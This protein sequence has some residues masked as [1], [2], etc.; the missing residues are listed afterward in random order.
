M[1]GLEVGIKFATNALFN[2]LIK[3]INFVDKTYTD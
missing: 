3:N 1:S 2:L